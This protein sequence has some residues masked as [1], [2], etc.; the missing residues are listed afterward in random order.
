MA[1][2]VSSHFFIKFAECFRL[3]EDRS[4]EKSCR[5]LTPDITNNRKTGYCKLFET[6]HVGSK[7]E[8][9][10]SKGVFKMPVS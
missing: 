6:F 10:T 8:A 3:C 5:G 9:A 2:G 1:D 7:A 4:L